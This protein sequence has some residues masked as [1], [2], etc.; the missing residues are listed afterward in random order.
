MEREDIKKAL[1]SKLQ[2]EDDASSTN[3]RKRERE[4]F[5]I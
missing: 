2:R 4:R 1:A 3:L 5:D